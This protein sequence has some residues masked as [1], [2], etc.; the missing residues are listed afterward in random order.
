M[1][2]DLLLGILIS[3]GVI[4]IIGWSS[5]LRDSNK[6]TNSAEK[7][8]MG[9][10]Y[11]HTQ[12]NITNPH[13]GGRGRGRGR[14]RTSGKSGKVH[15]TAKTTYNRVASI[16]KYIVTRIVT[17]LFLGPL[18][19]YAIHYLLYY[20]FGID[21]PSAIANMFTTKREEEPTIEDQNLKWN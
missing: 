4:W 3:L 15:K 2:H 6:D 18:L 5:Y 21:I 9:N 8:Y 12:I 17:V 19:L 10:N 16:T 11:D 13:A 20:L 1:Q 14:G 7:K